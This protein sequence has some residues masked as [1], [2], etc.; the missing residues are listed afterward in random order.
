ML[1]KKVITCVSAILLLSAGLVRAQQ[2][3]VP[4]VL[5]QYPELIVHNGKI[6]TADDKNTVAQAVAVRDGKFLA[7]GTN[8]EILRLA[9]PQTKKIDLK[10]K[11]VVP[12]FIDTHLHQAF[13]GQVSKRGASGRASFKT[14]E[15]GLE[16][17][18]RLVEG[19]PPGDWVSISVPRNKAFFSVTIEDLDP[20]SPN[21]PVVL[22]TQG[23]DTTVNSMAM[24]LSKIPPDTPGMNKFPNGQPDGRLEGWAAGIVLYE[25]KPWPN[26]DEVVH[27]QK[28]LFAEANAE[29]LTTIMA[30][31]QGLS[32]SVFRDLWLRGELTARVRA[33]HEMMRM[34][35]NGEAFLKRMGNLSYFGDDMLKIIGTTVGPV[36]GADGDGASLTAKPRM[37]VLEDSAFGG[38]GQ[39]KWLGHGRAGHSPHEWDSVAE[40]VKM[41]SEYGSVILANRYGWNVTSV[42]SAG[43]E[44]T[45][46]TLKAYEAASKEK[47]LQ[48]QW[49]ID[50]QP[51]Q[52]PDTHRLIKDLN[53][54][55]SLYFYTPGGGGI[56]GMLRQYGADRMN[57]MVPVRTFI[58]D[59]VTPVFEADTMQYPFFAPMYNLELFVTRRSPQLEGKAGVDRVYGPDEKASRMEALYMMTKWAAKY[60]KEEDRLGTIEP[61]KLADMAVLGGD[62]L[63]VPE[64]QLF[65]QLPVLMTIL[66]GKVV[67]EV[68]TKTPT[69]KPSRRRF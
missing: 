18:K 23:T 67:Y 38:L 10:G 51:M 69:N 44:S 3:Q 41:K 47:P 48:G 21:N 31:A 60:S 46:I 13:A 7:V 5:I 12:G 45:R 34:N 4:A 19:T 63:T 16:E 30:R 49:G 33:A 2:G 50:H 40:D 43:D 20:I 1:S 32:I 53:V 36:D 66:G 8:D 52:T 35:P 57:E 59:G 24:K 55:P 61:G 17:V 42:H 25:A 6:I 29:G 26:Y 62:F 22:T 14:K 11:S 28:E 56:E 54:I 39:N 64:D 37:T 27:E 65:E 9:G 15:S 68:E 58:E